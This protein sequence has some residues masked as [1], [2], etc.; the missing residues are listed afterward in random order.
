MYILSCTWYVPV[1]SCA[2]YV[3]TSMYHA[4][5]QASAIRYIPVYTYLVRTCQC[6][7]LSRCIAFTGFPP[8]TVK[9]SMYA[10]ELVNTL[11]ID[12]CTRKKLNP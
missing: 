3:P 8:K 1:F 11:C 2:W 12:V 9:T 7:D 4:I 10:F 6:Q 5:V